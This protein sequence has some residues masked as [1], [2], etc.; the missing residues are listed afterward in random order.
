MS[1]G[2]NVGLDVEAVE[3]GVIGPKAVRELAGVT[4]RHELQRLTDANW[5]LQL[6]GRR[7]LGRRLIVILQDL[8]RARHFAAQGKFRGIGQD[9]NLLET[10]VSNE[11]AAEL[12]DKLQVV[13]IGIQ[14]TGHLEI[15]FPGVVSH[16][17]E[18][19]P[20]AKA[21]YRQ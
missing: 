1:G 13:L 15:P 9:T 16:E 11:P 14:L 4:C 3:P 12:T 20:F 7:G 17:G 18:G 19:S 10:G 6:C 5:C 8:D 21:L 2:A